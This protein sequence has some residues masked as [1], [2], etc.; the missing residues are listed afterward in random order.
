MRKLQKFLVKHIWIISLII[1]LAG[2]LRNALAFTNFNR[3]SQIY[4]VTHYVLALLTPNSD[5]SLTGDYLFYINHDTYQRANY[6]SI[7][8]C[9]LIII[10]SLVYLKSK[11]ARNRII[12]ICFAVLFWF[13]LIG[14]AFSIV[15]MIYFNEHYNWTNILF[16]SLFAIF[17]FTIIYQVLSYFT[18]HDKLRIDQ[19]GK[20]ELANHSQR[21]FNFIIDYCSS[22][23][24]TLGFLL[25]LAI[26][27]RLSFFKN[28]SSIYTVVLGIILYYFAF[29]YFF[30]SS[31]G[32]YFTG[33]KVC[34]ADGKKLGVGKIVLR[35]LLRFIPF[36]AFS[37]LFMERGWHDSI[38]ETYVY[39]I[40]DKN[41]FNHKHIF[42]CFGFV[43]LIVLIKLSIEGIMSY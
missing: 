37:F 17:W 25:Y 14:I 5:L 3:D 10:G 2:L 33:T 18:S 31:I 6:F 21:I 9:I 27:L 15:S 42:L 41:E 7:A 1:G 20:Y 30:Q 32:K 13:Q 8:F 29:E 16:T 26:S 23:V 39:K 40:D 43:F 28:D 36:E 24:L 12:K 34:D 35:T 38:S 4:S 11:G 19:N 22:F